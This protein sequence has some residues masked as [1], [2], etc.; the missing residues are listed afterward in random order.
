MAAP[1]G[2]GTPT[3]KNTDLEDAYASSQ[4]EFMYIVGYISKDKHRLNV[5]FRKATCFVLVGSTVF[6]T[7]PGHYWCYTRDNNLKYWNI[8]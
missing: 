3:L 8:M 6:L 5:R 2:V 4:V 7:V 1:R